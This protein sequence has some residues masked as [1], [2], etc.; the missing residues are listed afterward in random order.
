M[1]AWMLL[2]VLLLAGAGATAGT[3]YEWTDSSGT[4]HFSTEPPEAGVEARTRNLG[5]GSEGSEQAT[6][7]ARVR[8]I[9][10]RDFRGAVTQLR[11]LES[12]ASAEPQWLAAKEFAAERVEQW[13]DD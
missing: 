11:E 12:A 2:P 4:T 13:C 9:R 1:A 3:V 10:C 6:P 7:S 8:E 5:T